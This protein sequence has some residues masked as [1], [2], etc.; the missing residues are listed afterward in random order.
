[1]KSAMRFRMDSG[2][3]LTDITV[4]RILNKLLEKI[5]AREYNKAVRKDAVGGR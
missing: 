2:D 1:M 5:Y 3:V 4:G